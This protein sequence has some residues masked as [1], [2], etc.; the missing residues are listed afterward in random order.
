M[1]FFFFLWQP[2]Q[3]SISSQLRAKLPVSVQPFI[4]WFLEPPEPMAPPLGII[5]CE[6]S[7][8]ATADKNLDETSR[9]LQKS[10]FLTF[11]LG[12]INGQPFMLGDDVLTTSAGHGRVLFPSSSDRLTQASPMSTFCS[13]RS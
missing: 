11:H 5:K 4:R 3:T 9:V 7:F 8:R 12:R 6:K 2:K 10:H 13:S 1:I